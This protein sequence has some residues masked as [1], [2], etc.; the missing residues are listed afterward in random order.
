MRH[1]FLS[2]VS[3]EKEA[4]NAGTDRLGSQIENI[5]W[6]FFQVFLHSGPLL[7]LKVPVLST[8]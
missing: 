1:V 4:R 3:N 2:F 5:L 7:V 8:P 6:D